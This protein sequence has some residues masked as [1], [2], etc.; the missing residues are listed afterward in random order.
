MIE[1]YFKNI[2]GWNFLMYLYGVFY[3]KDFEGVLYEDKIIG[4]DKNDDYVFFGGSYIYS[5]KLMNVYVLIDSD[6]DCF[7]WIYYLYV[8]FYKDINIGLLG[9]FM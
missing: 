7:M 5:W 9:N 4:S 1:I 6:D 8:L 3:R 2:V